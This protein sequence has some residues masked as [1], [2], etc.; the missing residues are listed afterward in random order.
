MQTKK[1]LRDQLTMILS[2]LEKAWG[3]AVVQTDGNEDY[4]PGRW[5]KLQAWA[6]LAKR[7]KVTKAEL[8]E[9]CLDAA[10]ALGLAV[11][12]SGETAALP[13][14]PAKPKESKPKKGSSKQE[15]PGAKAAREAGKKKRSG[16][17]AYAENKAKA[18]AKTKAKVEE[19]KATQRDAKPAKPKERQRV[20]V[21]TNDTPCWLHRKGQR[22]EGVLHADGT[23]TV[24]KTTY[25]TPSHAGREVGQMQACN[26]WERWRYD[27]N[28]TARPVDHL[29]INSKGYTL[30]GPRVAD[31]AKR[32]EKLIARR[33]KL[34]ERVAKL[35]DQLKQTKADIRGTEREVKL[36]EKGAA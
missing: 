17:K 5:A 26:G 6:S 15:S 28:G 10:R 22:H 36:A 8:E 34:E 35:Q 18:D 12:G 31:P 27:D 14:K 9:G 24:G 16:D 13:E 2:D 23:L 20:L 32:L 30:S 3:S 25:N 33:E 19:Q 4:D 7:K 11:S 29:R 21:V 1:E